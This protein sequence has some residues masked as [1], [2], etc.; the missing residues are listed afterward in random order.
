MFGYKKRPAAPQK[1]R[2]LRF[3][4]LENRSLLSANPTDFATVQDVNGLVNQIDLIAPPAFIVG[5]D[6]TA[7][8]TINAHPLA[9][10]PSSAYFTPATIRKAYGFDKLPY[11]GAGQTIAIVVAYND[12]N[13][14]NNLKTFDAQYG[15]PDP[16]VTIVRQHG[17]GGAS[18]AYDAWWAEEAAMDVEWAHAIAPKANLMLLQAFDNSYTN[19]MSMVDWARN[20]AGVSVVSMSFA[21]AE[22]AGET[23]LDSHFTTPAGHSPVTFIAA[24]G[25][26]GSGAMYPSA[27][28]NVLSVGGTKLVDGTIL[29]Y[30]I[31]SE[32][33]WTGSGGGPSTVESK[34]AYQNGFQNTTKRS[35]PDV[36]YEGDPSTGFNVYFA[37]G[38]GWLGT[39]G[40]SAGAPQWAGLIALANQGRAQQLKLHPALAN[41]IQ[42]IY[43]LPASD[44]NDI[45]GGSNGQF[46]AAAGYDM[47]TGRGS[48]KADLIVQH[49]IAAEPPIYVIGPTGGAAT[50]SPA[51]GN[52]TVPVKY[53]FASIA[54]APADLSGPAAELAFAARSF[55]LV[56][57][58]LPNMLSGPSHDA[59][60]TVA[61]K[62]ELLS[63]A[64]SGL[65]LLLANV[66]NEQQV[67]HL[68]DS[69]FDL[70]DASE[71]G[72]LSATKKTPAIQPIRVASWT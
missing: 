16:S 25:D 71:L 50:M 18:A 1:V 15:L 32:S 59:V 60:S 3:E 2:G 61:P 53:A 35:T 67:D 62:S 20:S 24:S 54:T 30:H 12:P 45:V 46:T 4:I 27:S 49:L 28:P 56:E 6:V 29:G 65:N 8:P 64:K 10:G 23:A 51:T 40:T 37:G 63:T 31:H 48:P 42:D 36:A 19:L 66:H 17:P 52:S 44:F 9:S 58:T 38:G 47:V 21:S 70:G 33:G 69:L 57:T 55:G 26:N 41:A 14:I 7:Q 13:T 22:F 34:P 68:I 5:G 43:A 72:V 11:D 39:A